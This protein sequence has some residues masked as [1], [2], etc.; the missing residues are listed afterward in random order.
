MLSRPTRSAT[1]T[2]KYGQF[3]QKTLHVASL[4]FTPDRAAP[5]ITNQSRIIMAAMN[6]I[7]AESPSSVTIECRLR[8]IDKNL[9]FRLNKPLP[10]RSRVSTTKPS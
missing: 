5:P 1:Q 2:Y 4:C 3:E 8:T 10:E 7:N 9:S 6:C